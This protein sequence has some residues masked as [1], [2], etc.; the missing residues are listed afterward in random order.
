MGQLD[1]ASIAHTSCSVAAHARRRRAVQIPP[2]TPSRDARSPCFAAVPLPALPEGTDSSCC[3]PLPSPRVVHVGVP[4]HR[5]ELPP[6]AQA[7]GRRQWRAVQQ[8][9][10]P[11]E[12]RGAGRC[13]LPE[14]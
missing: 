10:F 7:H 6:P 9:L 11:T 2:C 12:A 13:P 3:A 4:L 5:R 8:A 14:G 1:W